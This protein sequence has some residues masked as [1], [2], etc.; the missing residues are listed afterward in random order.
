MYIWKIDQLNKEL[1]TGTLNESENFKYLMANSILYSISMIPYENTNNFD[2]INGIL[3]VFITIIGLW[4]IY[5]C[6]GGSKGNNIIQ[7]YLSVGWV[8]S[9]RFLCLLLVPAIIIAIILREM[10]FGG[11]PDE[12]TLFDVV[13]MQAIIVIYF[14]WVAKHI[15]YIAKQENA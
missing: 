1:I 7:R 13:F 5:K 12:S 14:L 10:F 3:N 8:I 9:V 11:L 6:N 15:K 4:F 2:V